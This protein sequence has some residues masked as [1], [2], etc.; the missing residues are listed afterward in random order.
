MVLVQ[1]ELKRDVVE[2]YVYASILGWVWPSPIIH[3]FN[4]EMDQTNCIKSKPLQL[5]CLFYSTTTPFRKDT[6]TADICAHR[7]EISCFG[8]LKEVIVG[9]VKSYFVIT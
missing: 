9:S 1:F 3:C 5:T 8:I 2:T 6:E 4:G 7:V